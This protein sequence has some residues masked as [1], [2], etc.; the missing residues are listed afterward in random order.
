MQ[1]H[2]LFQKGF[3]HCHCRRLRFIVDGMKQ[4]LRHFT[5]EGLAGHRAGLERSIATRKQAA[6]DW[7]RTLAPVV[8]SFIKQG[9][10]DIPRIRDSLN[11][12]RVPNRA[13]VPWTYASTER[14]VHN[15]RRLGL[16]S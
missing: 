6:D 15:L 9:T 11:T 1:Q 14:L 7:S 4:R 10:I 16:V 12:S 3:I 5:P 13:K 8:Q 2:G